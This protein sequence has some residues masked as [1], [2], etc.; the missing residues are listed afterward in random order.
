MKM[1]K[2]LTAALAIMLIAAL[3]LC[4]LAET[5]IV[6]TDKAKVFKK[7]NKKSDV[8]SRLPAGGTVEVF[9]SKGNWHHIHYINKKGVEKTGWIREKDLRGGSGGSGGASSDG[10]HKHAWTEWRV[11][12]QPTCKAVGRK[13]RTCTIC[14]VTKEKEIEKAKHTW[15]KWSV[16]R[17]AT[18]QKAGEKTSTCKVCGAKGSQKIKKLAHQFGAWTVN[19]AATCSEVGSQTRAC[20]VCGAKETEEI[21]KLAHSFGAWTMTTPMTRVSDG[22][23]V[24]ACTACGMEEREAVKAEPSLIRKDRGEAVKAVQS[25]LNDLGY[26]AGRAD[27]AYGP[28]LDKAFEGFA[29]D[30]GVSF[31]VGWL[32]PAQLDALTTAWIEGQPEDKWMGVNEGL[33]L[34]VDPAESAD[35]MRS[36]NWILASEDR[37]TLV[38]R[39]VLMGLGGDH[40][41]RS[42]DMV[43]VLDSQKLKSGT[44]NSLGGTFTVPGNLG[45]GGLLSFAAVVENEKTGEVWLSN[46]VNCAKIG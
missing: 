37:E 35:G 12:K 28:K 14:G 7:S 19:Q 34:T 45:E 46:T 25:M 39:A 29:M 31:A 21:P 24:H 23:R 15:G 9:E 10:S 5:R 30:K 16:A 33:T 42:D 36:F 41:F 22:E 3:A 26:D 18:C 13:E 38:L 32:M 4:A 20:S 27:G 17:A 40:D 43:A 2:I 6:D 11:T 44:A 1:K 8:I